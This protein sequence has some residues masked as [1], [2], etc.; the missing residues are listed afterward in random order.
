MKISSNKNFQRPFV[1]SIMDSAKNYS[2]QFPPRPP[3]SAIPRSTPVV[4]RS[5]GRMDPISMHFL[6]SL[7]SR[8]A[9]G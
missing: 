4:G 5:L 1:F 3:H 9:F 2:V 7:T 6:L 8:P